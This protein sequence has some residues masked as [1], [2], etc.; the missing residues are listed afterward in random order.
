MIKISIIIKRNLDSLGVWNGDRMK[1]IWS[2]QCTSGKKRTRAMS[3]QKG[4]QW[5]NQNMNFFFLYS[6]CTMSATRRKAAR[7][8]KRM[9][10]KSVIISWTQMVIIFFSFHF[11]SFSANHTSNVDTIQWKCSVI[12]EY[13]INAKFSKVLWNWWR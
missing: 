7:F 5:I 3:H 11:L 9:L 6:A 1:K 13:M 8:K 10:K 12:P 2:K 4:S